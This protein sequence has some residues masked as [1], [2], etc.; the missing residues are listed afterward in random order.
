MCEALQVREVGFDRLRNAGPLTPERATT[1]PA[2]LEP[3]PTT[4][5]TVPGQAPDST[6]AIPEPTAPTGTVP[7]VTL[8]PATIPL[9]AVPTTLPIEVATSPLASAMLSTA[10]LP[11]G[12]D[13]SE[14]VVY[15]NSPQGDEPPEECPTSSALTALDGAFEFEM[16]LRSPDDALDFVTYWVGE[17]DTAEAASVNAASLATF[18]ECD[19]SETFSMFSIVTDFATIEGADTVAVMSLT[20]DNDDEFRGTTEI[21]VAAVGRYVAAVSLVSQDDNSDIALDIV[22]RAVAKL[23]RANLD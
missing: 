17:F 1:E 16:S 6:V 22:T 9:P 8:P 23:N 12:W 13:A 14:I 7:P 18:D 21:V 3:I 10:D 19:T 11:T 2:P 4:V 15:G 5:H 20:I